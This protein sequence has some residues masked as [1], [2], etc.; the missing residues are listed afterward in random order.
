MSDIVNS[1]NNEKLAKINER[2]KY[3]ENKIGFHKS[4]GNSAQAHKYIPELSELQRQV[5]ENRDIGIFMV[6]NE[7]LKVKIEKLTKTHDS[8]IKEKNELSLKL[9]EGD[10]AYNY[11]REYHPTLF[12]K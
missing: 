2:I 7:L 10:I 8:L 9:K 4:A 11:L 6:E 12:K 1:I 3:L 5:K